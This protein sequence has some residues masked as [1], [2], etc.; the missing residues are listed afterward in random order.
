MPSIPSAARIAPWPVAAALVAGGVVVW[1]ARRYGRDR[2]DQ[3]LD[4]DH[5]TRVALRTAGR[6]NG[7]SADGYTRAEADYVAMLGE[8]AAPLSAYTGTQLELGAGGIRVMDRPSWIHA[9]VATFRDLLRPFE[10]LFRETAGSRHDLPGVTAAGRLALST[11]IGVLLG[12]LSRRVLG[13][14]DIS[15]LGARP[16]GPGKLYFVEPNVEAVQLRLGLPHRE[17]RVWLALHEATHAHEFEGHPWVRDYLNSTL[18]TYLDSLLDQIRD[19]GGTLKAFVT[20]AVDRRFVPATLIEAIMTPEQREILSRIQALM[21]LLEGY[22]NHVMNALGRELLP[23]FAT[24]EGR[25]EERSRQRGGAEKLFL[26]LTGL[27]MKLDQYRLGAAFVDRVNEQRGIA[28]VNRVWERME[29]LPTE[30]EIRDASL[31]VQRIE[32]EEAAA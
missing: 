32:K 26:R 16:T 9:N 17:F 19:G 4:W 28:F 13:Q 3:I 12:Y 10:E 27:Q 11:E 1:A 29:N 20:K 31:W 15:L 18:Q 22:S 7:A 25:I 21:C 5:A 2:A 30:P 24:I 14:Y 8:I 6:E 23:H